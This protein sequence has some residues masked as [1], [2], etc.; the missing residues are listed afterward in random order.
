LLRELHIRNFAV[1]ETLDLEFGSGMNVFTGETGAGKSIIVDAMG[2]ILGDRADS[3]V[4]RGGQDRADISAVFTLDANPTARAL[5]GE[6]EIETED[7]EVIIRRVISQEGRSRGFINSTPVPIQQ[8]KSLGEC[9]VELHGQHSHQSLLKSAV[10][11]ALL[12]FYG[13]HEEQLARVRELFSRWSDLQARLGE[14]SGSNEDREARLA[15]LEYQVDELDSL[16]LGEHEYA[17]VSA[18]VKRLTHL[19]DI[20]AT[21]EAAHRSLCTDDPSALDLCAHHHQSLAR[22]LEQEPALGSAVELVN[23]AVIQLQEVASE[24]RDYLDKQDTDPGH[25]AAAE[26]RLDQILETARKHRIPPEALNEHAAQL[27]RDLE[28]LKNSTEQYELLLE[29]ANQTLDQ[30]REAAAKLSRQRTDS[31]KQMGLEIST[32][33]ARLGMPA[34]EFEISVSADGQASPSASGMDRVEYLFTAN[35]GQALK[36][37][38]KVASG[39]ELSRISLAIQVT[40]TEHLAAGSLVFDE[41]DSGIGGGT[42]SIVGE[43]LHS[44]SGQYQVFCVTHLAQVAAFGDSHYHVAKMAGNN[45][46]RTQVRKLEGDSRVEEIARMMGGARITEQSLAHAREM[47]GAAG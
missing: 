26:K 29:Q 22:L 18:E 37:V 8:L 42:A 27:R 2:L 43:L 45:V 9:L 35:P 1:V 21:V 46:T 7:D 33:L 19:G 17:G 30:Y 32:T 23:N 16:A 39:G 3:S 38:S 31:A 40:A 44:L 20:M 13:H 28:F 24:L 36:P 12:D 15:L 5:L 11:R 6:L 34:A 4:V 14:L 10:Q 41:V 47:L 25:L